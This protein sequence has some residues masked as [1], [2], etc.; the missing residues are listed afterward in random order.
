[1][2]WGGLGGKGLKTATEPVSGPG[3]SRR[4]EDVVQNAFIVKA[5]VRLRVV[6]GNH[7]PRVNSPW[8]QVKPPRDPSAFIDVPREKVR[9]RLLRAHAKEGLFYEKRN[10]EHIERVDLANYD[11]VQRSRARADLAIDLVIDKSSDRSI[12]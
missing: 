4:I 11:I 6:E 9:A 3:C 7:L 8:W 2:G 10:H 1:M 5:E 12:F